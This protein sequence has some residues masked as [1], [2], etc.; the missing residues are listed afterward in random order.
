MDSAVLAAIITAAFA[1]LVALYTQRG[2]F[3]HGKELVVL[4]DHL[5]AESRHQE[6]KLS[7]RA[8]LDNIREPLLTAAED[9]QHRIWNIRK[10][11]FLDYLQIADSH[12][13]EV[14]LFGTLH[15]F[16]TYWALQE[17]LYSRT[18][19]L[20][21]ESDPDTKNVAEL[22]GKI[23]QI[24]ASDSTAG[25]DLIFWREEQRAVAEL[26]FDMRSASPVP[27]IMG[28]ATFRNR[29]DED[30]R[31]EV[32]EDLA[33]WLGSFAKDLQTTGVNE[34]RRL[35]ELDEGLTGLIKALRQGRADCPDTGYQ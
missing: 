5:D 17:L 22:V 23:A 21:F 1:L 7:A 24:C 9:L 25:L 3:K 28:F 32:A 12:R 8:E 4:K 19:I 10:N 27:P 15:R 30:T 26:M 6:R 31:R 13:R 16:A 29:Y 18:N 20:R 11:H 35:K 34:N 2:Q 14:A 33:F